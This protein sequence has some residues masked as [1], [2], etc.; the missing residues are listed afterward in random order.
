MN[1]ISFIEFGLF[2]YIVII[3]SGTVLICGTN[4]TVDIL[5][6]IL[7]VSE[8]DLN[9]TTSKKGILAGAPFL[10]MVNMFEY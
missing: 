4:D 2:N 5:C 10:G 9:L 3:L 7:P 8:C 6:Y 1:V